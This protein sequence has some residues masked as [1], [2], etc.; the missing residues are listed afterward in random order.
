MYVCI[1]ADLGPPLLSVSDRL[2]PVD[3]APQVPINEVTQTKGA[4]PVG[5]PLPAPQ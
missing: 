2:S 5:L 1:T 3:D 4:P